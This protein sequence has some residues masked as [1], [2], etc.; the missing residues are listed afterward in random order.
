M[1]YFRSLLP[2]L[3]EIVCFI[4]NHV[5]S[6]KNIFKWSS[7]YWWKLF[8]LSSIVFWFDRIFSGSDRVSGWLQREFSGSLPFYIIF[9]K[10]F[11]L[12]Q[13]GLRFNVIEASGNLFLTYKSIRYTRPP[14][15]NTQ[16]KTIQFLKHDKSVSLNI[17][18]KLFKFIAN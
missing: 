2:H 18:I 10:L 13:I 6:N 16:K 3:G 15:I 4:M 11:Y 1:N 7:A 5:Y 12:A 14:L 8:W 17:H 9:R